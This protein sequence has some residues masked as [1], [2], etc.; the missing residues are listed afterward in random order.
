GRARDAKGKA[1]AAGALP[2]KTMTRRGGRSYFSPS[3]SPSIVGEAETVSRVR[4]A[5]PKPRALDTVPASPKKPPDRKA[6]GRSS[7]W[8]LGRA[9]PQPQKPNERS[10]AQHPAAEPFS[11][12]SRIGNDLSFQAHLALEINLDF[13]LISGL[14][15]ATKA[16]AFHDLEAAPPASLQKVRH[17]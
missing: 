15:N 16:G 14:E 13:R 8:E 12:S 11:G 5:A 3:L 9:I 1:G 4:Y 17:Q 10:I 7:G 6:K 2:E